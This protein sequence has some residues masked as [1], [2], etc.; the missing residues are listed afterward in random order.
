MSV[1]NSPVC[2]VPSQA[3]DTEHKLLSEICPLSARC[4][5]LPVQHHNPLTAL[6]HVVKQDG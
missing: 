1:W 2:P 6:K 4:M 3:G 5:S